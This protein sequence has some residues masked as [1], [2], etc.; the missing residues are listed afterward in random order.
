MSVVDKVISLGFRLRRHPWDE[1]KKIIVVGFDVP[2]GSCPDKP[3]QPPTRWIICA[4]D[5]VS[6]AFGINDR[7]HATLLWSRTTFLPIQKMKLKVC[8]C[9]RRWIWAHT[10]RDWTHFWWRLQCGYKLDVDNLE[11]LRGI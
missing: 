10:T 4:N 7:A 6:I 2:D 3:Q 9:I 1:S 11:R 8:D 5:P